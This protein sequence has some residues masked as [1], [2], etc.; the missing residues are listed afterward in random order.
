MDGRTAAATL[1]VGPQATREQIR[2]AFR[3]RAKV[4]HPD[5]GPAGSAER[6]IAIRAAAEQLLSEARAT[7]A[8]P[9]SPSAST[10]G[11]AGVARFETEG[12]VRPDRRTG[13]IDLTDT[14]RRTARTG[15]PVAGHP[16][17]A[18]VPGPVRRDTNG[19]S[20]EDHLTAALA[21]G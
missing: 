5:S 15:R 19:L 4:L 6:F 13:S 20:F 9:S 2:Q 16:S 17:G 11:A 21:K 3:A 10:D 14:A 1:G 8:A 18:G 12:V 7:A